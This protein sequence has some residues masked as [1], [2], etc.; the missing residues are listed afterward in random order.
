MS[1][2][3]KHIALWLVLALVFLVIFSV[4]SKQ[5]GREPEIV[6]SDFMS[7]V[8][9][10]DIQE[11][12]IQGHNIQGKYKNGERFRTFAPT[13][14]DLVKSLREKKVKIA[15]KPEEDSPWYMVF[16]LNWFPMLLLIGVWVF[17]MRQMQV[18]GGKAMSFRQE[19]RQ[20]AHGKS[21]SGHVSPM[22][23][24]PTKLKT[25]FRRSSLS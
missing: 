12:V 8:D 25:I 14:P 17:F 9:R 4:F 13:D 22:S 3:H 24:A 20:A 5:H 2:S 15:A 6:F 7:S 21:A 23:R 1:Q 16:L 18:G 19:P 11:V 10:G